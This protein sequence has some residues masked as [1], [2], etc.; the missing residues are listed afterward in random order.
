MVGGERLAII[1]PNNAS[2][3]DAGLTIHIC[4]SELSTGK[5]TNKCSRLISKV[6]I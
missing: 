1:Y 4:N 3:G 2:F 6:P 5:A